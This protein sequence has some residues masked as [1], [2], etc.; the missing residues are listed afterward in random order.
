MAGNGWPDRRTQAIKYLGE[1]TAHAEE[2]LEL[3]IELDMQNMA[4]QA[5]PLQTMYEEATQVNPKQQN[6]ERQTHLPRLLKKQPCE[7]GTMQPTEGTVRRSRDPRLKQRH[8]TDVQSK[9]TQSED[10]TTATGKREDGRYM[11]TPPIK[12][13]DGKSK[14]AKANQD[15]L[16]CRQ[17]ERERQLASQGLKQ[18]EESLE[19]WEEKTVQYMEYLTNKGDMDAFIKDEYWHSLPDKVRKAERRRKKYN[20]R[21]KEFLTVE[22][23]TGG[24]RR[25]NLRICDICGQIFLEKRKDRDSLEAHMH[26][27]H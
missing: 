11:D 21:L 16:D 24:G 27:K 4:P 14:E 13:G 18:R 1:V 9:S 12:R 19:R 7:G 2:F 5:T 23:T 22:R 15:L 17:E 3:L 26:N 25:L 10:C 8:S 6:S 20:R